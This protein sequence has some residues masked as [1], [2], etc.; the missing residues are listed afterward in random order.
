M[1]P[2]DFVRLW[3]AEKESLVSQF[4]DSSSGNTVAGAIEALGLPASRKA[5]LRRILDLALT[6]TM[7]TLLLGLDGCASI[8]GLQESYSVYAESGGRLAGEGELE[9]A[10]YQVFHGS[11]QDAAPGNSLGDD[12]EP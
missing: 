6:D 7:Y 9:V 12:R 1:T 8:G 5:E 3:W 10:A 4:L 2:I 11:P